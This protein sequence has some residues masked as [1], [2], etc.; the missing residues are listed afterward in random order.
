M[1][2]KC[3]LFDSKL[4]IFELCPNNDKWIIPQLSRTSLIAGTLVLS[5]SL[6]YWSVPTNYGFTNYVHSVGPTTHL[7]LN[8][9]A[10]LLILCQLDC[11]ITLVVVSAISTLIPDAS[12]TLSRTPGCFI[13]LQCHSRLLFHNWQQKPLSWDQTILLHLWTHFIV[14]FLAFPTYWNKEHV[15]SVFPLSLS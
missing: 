11:V 12:R 9:T 1:N 8:T 4:A 5:K 2:W 13:H 3:S 14:P 7:T 6:T 10:L 15:W